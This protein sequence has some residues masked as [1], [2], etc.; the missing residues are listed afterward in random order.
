[1]EYWKI[2]N[3]GAAKADNFKGWVLHHRLELTL[4]GDEVHS[5]DSLK[6]LNMYYNR[7]YFELIYLPR[8]VHTSLHNRNRE[9]SEEHRRK[10]S[11]AAKNRH[12]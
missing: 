11:V 10:L 9:F 2:E 5:A 3:Y 6:R 4:D 1:M 8:K 12:K 7:P